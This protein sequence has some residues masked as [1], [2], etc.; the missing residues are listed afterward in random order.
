M[1]FSSDRQRR[2]MFA[3]IFSQKNVLS[4]TDEER[5]VLRQKVL[6]KTIP[7]SDI[8][9]KRYSDFDLKRI[10]AGSD[11]RVYD[12][13]DIYALKVAKRKRGLLQNDQ[14]GMY[15]PDITPPLEERGADY[16][17][18]DKAEIDRR[19][20]K[21]FVSKFDKY[22][23]D[24]FDRKT[25]DLQQTFQEIDEEYDTDMSGCLSCDLAWGDFIR[26]TSW[27]WIDDKPVL[28]DAGT[29]CH[30]ALTEPELAD[31]D[32]Q[33]VLQKRRAARKEG[34]KDL[35]MKPSKLEE[36]AIDEFGF[37]DDPREGGY[38]LSNGLML[39]FSS[40]REGGRG[41]DRVR[42]HSEISTAFDE[43]D[44]S[45]NVIGMDEFINDTGAI[46]MSV[47]D[48][49]VNLRVGRTPTPQQTDVIMGVSKGKS[50]YVENY[51]DDNIAG[52]LKLD[53]FES[54]KNQKLRRFLDN[55]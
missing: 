4:L 51:N 16:V 26:P 33:A 27:G 47:Q 34:Y 55:I 17:L 10:G 5:R 11:R 36:R 48:E 37:T 18:V 32:W 35:S 41:G 29:L 13:D 21:E 42:D 9:M 31:K 7:D 1:R 14:E 25:S 30:S 39:D 52:Y 12:V 45:G 53:P 40:V 23:L 3:N 2:A 6:G 28:V 46:S 44:Q 8:A 49:Q 50:V 54:G 20:S 38:L 22:G 24:D 19:K 43:Y 15:Y